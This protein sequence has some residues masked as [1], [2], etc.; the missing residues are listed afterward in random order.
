MF[1]GWLVTKKE[2]VGSW[3]RAVSSGVRRR[4]GQRGDATRAPN[5]RRAKGNF[6]FRG[7]PGSFQGVPMDRF[8]EGCGVRCMVEPVTCWQPGERRDGSGL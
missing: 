4:I 5:E 8:G 6:Y 7:S 3:V 2:T 1:V